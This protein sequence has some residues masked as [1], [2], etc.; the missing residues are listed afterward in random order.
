LGA[1]MGV[2]YRIEGMIR[3]LL[4]SLSDGQKRKREM[5]RIF[6]ATSVVKYMKQSL[7]SLYLSLLL[8]PIMINISFLVKFD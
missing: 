3:N 1:I 5:E 2:S 6:L 4:L 7:I 8:N